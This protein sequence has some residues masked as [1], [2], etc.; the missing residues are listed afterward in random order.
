MVSAF[1]GVAGDATGDNSI[2]ARGNSPTGVLWRLEGIEI[3]N[4]NHFSD[5]GSTGGP[6][7]V[8]NSDMLDNSEFYTGAFAPE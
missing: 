3:P 5:E 6:I 4:P 8:L 7:N 1:P 2:V